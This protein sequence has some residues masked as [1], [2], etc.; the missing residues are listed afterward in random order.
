MRDPR[1]GGKG[2]VICVLEVCIWYE[3]V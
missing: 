3:N 2:L 1:D